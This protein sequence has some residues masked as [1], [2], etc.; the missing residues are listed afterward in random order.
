MCEGIYIGSIATAI[1]SEA[2]TTHRIRA[3]I[4][5]SGVSYVSSIP[6]YQ[7]D[8]DD[9]EV[10]D[11][12]LSEY[13]SKFA[14]GIRAINEAR[15][16]N[17]NVLVHCAAGINRSATLIGLYMISE[18]HQHKD[19]IDALQH[20]NCSRGVAVLTNPTFRAILRQAARGDI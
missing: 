19:V 13:M 16:Q 2:L 8:M 7:I 3:I 20:A 15:E 1:D 14:E 5:L 10:T 9:T 12:T 11:I 6:V 18:G 4:N 17:Y